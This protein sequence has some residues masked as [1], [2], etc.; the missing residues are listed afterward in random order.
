M[1]YALFANRKIYYTALLSQLQ[2]RLD[3][4][5][6]QRYDLMTYSANISDGEVTLEE[7]TGDASN[8]GNYVQFMQGAEA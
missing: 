1:G 4:I 7:I 5:N 2:M 3:E 8:Y 6:Q